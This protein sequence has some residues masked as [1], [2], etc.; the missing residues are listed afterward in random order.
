MC[1]CVLV[2]LLRAARWRRKVA[3]GS[4]RE[5]GFYGTELTSL[6]LALTDPLQKREERQMKPYSF[7]FFS[8]SR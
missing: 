1:P 7:L 2:A 4:G 6:L 3:V 5:K 8:L